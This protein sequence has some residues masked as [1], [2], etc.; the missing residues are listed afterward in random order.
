[1]KK[2]IRFSITTLLLLT[3]L[4]AV[5]VSHF[6]ISA[7][8]ALTRS[9]LAAAN[10][11]LRQLN[12]DD[13]SLV[14]AVLLPTFGPRQWRWRVFLPAG[15]RWRL[16]SSFDQLPESGLPTLV[17]NHDHIFLNSR[18]KPLA[19]GE[20]F[21]LGVAVHKNQTDRW[22]LTFQTLDRSTTFPI[23]Q[24]PAWLEERSSVGW[25]SRV[26]GKR[27]SESEP[28]NGPL[29][30]LRHRKA[31]EL[32]GGAITVDMEPTDGLMVWIEPIE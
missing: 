6:R 15:R 18:N 31:K 4:V 28:A 26:A 14:H 3:A 10:D 7:E 8:L 30:L 27:A 13:D 9:K 32:P 17:R 12:I 29:V 20:P 21:V 22:A 5:L 24:P 25:T 2:R 16:C 19:G 23:K 1:M 11:D